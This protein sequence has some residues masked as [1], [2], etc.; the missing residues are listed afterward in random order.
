MGERRANPAEAE[1]G[2]EVRVPYLA[3]DFVE[4]AMRL[5]P[6]LKLRNFTRKVVLRRLMRGRLPRRVLQR[7]KRGFNAPVSQWMRGELNEYL[8]EVIHERA[9]SLVDLGSPLVGQ[10]W[11]EHCAG[12]VDHG[13]KLW[14]L[15]VF[16]IW[17]ERVS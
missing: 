1:C 6:D 2:L 4:T 9:S 3:P 7:K 16:E 5:P 15:I 13:H 14:T 12:E 17:L 10:L 8:G 11:K